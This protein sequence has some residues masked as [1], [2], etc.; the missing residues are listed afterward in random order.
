MEARFTS[1]PKERRDIAGFTLI[2]F[3]FVIAIITILTG[4]FLP[5]AFEKL[6]K[7]DE[8]G[9]DSSLQA[10][11]AALASFYADLRAFPT[12]H[13]G[14]CASFPGSNNQ[15][16]FLAI[17][18]GFGSQVSNYPEA[19]TGGGNWDLTVNDEGTPARNN[20]ANHLVQND[21]DASGTPNEST[22]YRSTGRLGWKGPYLGRF[23][24]DPWGKTFIAYVGAMEANGKKVSGASGQHSGWILSAGPNGSLDTLPSANTLAG[25]DRGF[26]FHSQ[27]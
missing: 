24:L 6:R 1:R 27:N 7:A 2:E 16:V 21:P 12:C 3:V 8:A 15:L 23:S 25:D 20:G 9:A 14:S 18:D 17:G 13:S 19:A 10:I 4:V 11:A 26:I 22:D 5:L